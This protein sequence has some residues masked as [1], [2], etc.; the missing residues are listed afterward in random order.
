MKQT[1]ILF[2]LLLTLVTSGM[3]ARAADD[4]K[5]GGEGYAVGSYRDLSQTIA[6][7]GG[8]DITKPE[9]ADDYAKIF[10]CEQYRKSFKDDIEW[11]K[12]RSTIVDR[13][14]HKKDHSRTLYETYGEFQLGRYDIEGQFFPLTDQTALLNVGSIELFSYK[15]FTSACGDRKSSDYFPATIKLLLKRPL[16]LNTFRI[17]EDEAK[18]MLARMIELKNENRMVRGRIRFRV[19]EAPG[20]VISLNT[21]IGTTLKG[22]VT[23]IDFFIDKEMTQPAGPPQLAWDK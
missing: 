12:I 20:P 16:T 23:A 6:V 5:N 7:M 11:H 14:Q 3:A 18:K 13:V 17:P 4:T 22:E 8:V 10:Y 2:L 9:V 1:L 19:T 15:Q 21:V